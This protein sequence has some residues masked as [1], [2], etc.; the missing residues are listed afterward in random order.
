MFKIRQIVIVVLLLAQGIFEALKESGDFTQLEEKI[1][2]LTQQAARLLLTFA[3]E[4]IDQRLMAQREKTLKVIGSR[5][6][7]LISTM[8]E[9][10]IKRRMYRD[11]A[12]KYVFLL[13][14]ALGLASHRRISQRLQ[15][16]VLDLATEMPFRRAAKVLSYLVPAVSPMAVWSTAQAAGEEACKEADKLKKDVFEKGVVPK[17]QRVVDRLNIEGDEIRLKQQRGKSKYLDLKLLVGYEGKTGPRRRLENRHTVAGIT[18]GRGIWEEGSCVFG[19]KWALPEVKQIRIGGDG[20]SWIK[21]GVEHFPGAT[22]YLDLFHLRK[23][24]TEALS[25]TAAY[26]AVTDGLARLDKEAVL[27]ALDQEMSL[28]KGARKKRVRELKKYLLDN[29]SGI[30]QLPEE[31]RLGTIEGQVR[32]TIARRMKRIGAR[33]TLEGANR[34]GRLLAAKANGEL[35]RYVAKPKSTLENLLPEQTFMEKVSACHQEDLEAWLRATMPALYGPFA[36][37][38]WIKYVLKEIASVQ[39]PA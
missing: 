36:G 29:W 2:R 8:G 27:R 3:L 33:W 23:R 6:R 31:E 18:D 26:T 30:A 12:G 25:N 24:L 35:P 37:R 28:L 39:W 17:G 32:H 22:Y 19:Q 34:M 15:E 20:A 38:P 1:H 10:K 7:T 14:Q 9:I 13:D 11:E 5:E 16:L 21:R 4:E